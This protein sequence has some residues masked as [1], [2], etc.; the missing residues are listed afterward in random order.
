MA[1]PEMV[2]YGEGTEQH[3]LVYRPE[4]EP[5]RL[6]ILVHGGF[7]KAKYSVRNALTGELAQALVGRG[8]HVI[9]VEYRRVG[10]EGGGWPGSNEDVLAALAYIRANLANLVPG[11]TSTI[12]SALFG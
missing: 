10:H 9:D 3:L 1:A 7:W 12:R 2:Q 11:S 8:W 6:A 5:W 4:A